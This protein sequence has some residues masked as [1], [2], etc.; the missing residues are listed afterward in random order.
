MTWFVH[1]WVIESSAA[2]PAD[3]DVTRR[4]GQEDTGREEKEAEAGVDTPKGSGGDTS[5]STGFKVLGGFENKP[6]QKVSDF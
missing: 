1:V 4:E 3:S 6:A 5:T 2:S